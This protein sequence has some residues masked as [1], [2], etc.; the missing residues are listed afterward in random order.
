MDTAVRTQL[1]TRDPLTYQVPVTATG[2]E[3]NAYFVGRQQDAIV[4]M[5]DAIT[6]AQSE[7]VTIS[8]DGLLS[9]P[10]GSEP[11]RRWSPQEID[12]L[13]VSDPDAFDRDRAV[14]Y[15]L[16]ETLTWMRS[17]VGP[18]AGADNRHG[19]HQPFYV[20]DERTFGSSLPAGV[21]AL[22]D[23]ARYPHLDKDPMDQRWRVSADDLIGGWCVVLEVDTRTPAEG[24]FQLMEF[25][26][27]D[28]AQHVVDLHNGW[29]D[30]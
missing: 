17:Y 4:L 15:L 29:L 10:Y 24:A 22:A 13:D 1:G 19:L 8:A 27:A 3:L 21:D 26:S 7:A 28:L 6:G 9:C 20:L 25:V 18:V 11:T 2:G 5:R 16:V 12:D 14:A 30:R 23:L